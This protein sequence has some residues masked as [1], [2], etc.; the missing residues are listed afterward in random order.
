MVNKLNMIIDEDVKHFKRKMKEYIKQVETGESQSKDVAY[1]TK[2]YKVRQKHDETYGVSCE[3][4]HKAM[5][6]ALI[7]VQDSHNKTNRV[8][9]YVYPNRIRL[10]MAKTDARHADEYFDIRRGQNE[11]LELYFSSPSSKTKG[12]VEKAHIPPKKAKQAHVKKVENKLKSYILS[13]DLRELQ[14]IKKDNY[15]HIRLNG[16]LKNKINDIAKDRRVT[17]SNIVHQVLIDIIAGKIE[18]D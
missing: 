15:L 4:Y 7:K 2:R 3:D 5:L 12:R 1:I 14:S 17:V 9:L 10:K 6:K 16:N 18:V 13:V 11:G 8:R